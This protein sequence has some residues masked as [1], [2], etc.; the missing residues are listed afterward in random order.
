MAIF[1]NTGLTKETRK[2]LSERKIHKR[3]TWD[4]IVNRLIQIHD[5]VVL[6]QQQE[7]Q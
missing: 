2:L 6:N 4:D 3:E 5:E 1:T 7:Q